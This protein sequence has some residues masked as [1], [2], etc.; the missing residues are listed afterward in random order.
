MNIEIDPLS[1]TPI[2]QQIRDR[3]VE[4][5]ATGGLRRGDAVTPVRRLAA[6]FGI[7]PNTVAKAYDLLRKEGYLAANAKSGTFVACDAQHDTTDERFTAEWRA[8]LFTLLAEARAH[9]MTP[10]DVE[11]HVAL[12]AASLTPV[13]HD[14]GDG[15]VE[16][17]VR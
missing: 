5:I 2:Y 6:A 11:Q 14:A 15:S 10:A 12:A 16:E 13:D 7:N 4:A 8:R 1:A 17:V 3:V 9:G